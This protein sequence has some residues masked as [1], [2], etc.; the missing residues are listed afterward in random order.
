MR[1]ISIVVLA[2]AAAVV[3]GIAARAAGTVP[4]SV[5]YQGNSV[6]FTHVYL[7]SSPDMFDPKAT[8]RT[9]IL[10][11]ADIGDKI[12]ACYSVFC[13]TGL[14]LNGMTV[15]FSHNPRLTYWVGVKNQLKQVTGSAIPV[16]VF[17]PKADTPDHLAGLL[18]I[19]DSGIKGPKGTA[20]FDVT[21]TKSFTSR[22]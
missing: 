17:K 3:F 4:G 16:E 21:L 1:T 20:E 13:A 5:E 9:L 19:D 7:I 8:V 15:E 6:K 18:M 2:L 11:D 12:T 10:T 22:N 14:V